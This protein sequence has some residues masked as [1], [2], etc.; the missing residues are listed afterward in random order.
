MES[1]LIQA[2][3]IT[4]LCS[5]DFFGRPKF[6]PLRALRVIPKPSDIS[7]YIILGRRNG[8]NAEQVEAVLTMLC[9]A[10]EVLCPMLPKK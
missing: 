4:F 8:V 7:D 10:A 9:A 2:E 5:K 6:R 1:K 3:L